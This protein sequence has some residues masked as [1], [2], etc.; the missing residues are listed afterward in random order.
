MAGKKFPGGRLDQR[1]ALVRQ[2]LAWAAGPE[3]Y[4]IWRTSRWHRRR[5]GW[6][7]GT[8]DRLARDPTQAVAFCAR[9]ALVTGDPERVL[10]TL[11]ELAAGS[12]EAP[13]WN[14]TPWNAVPWRRPPAAADVPPAAGRFSRL[15]AVIAGIEEPPDGGMSDRPGG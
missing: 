3:I 10:R 15:A 1:V 11:A 9:L 6:L 8:I 4:A 13:R 14:A 2:R 5:P 7:W 12:W